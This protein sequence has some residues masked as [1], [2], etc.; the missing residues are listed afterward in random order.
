MKRLS[1]VVASRAPTDLL[2]LG[3]IKGPMDVG[4]NYFQ[5]NHR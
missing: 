1:A 4:E 5:E 3:L 2:L